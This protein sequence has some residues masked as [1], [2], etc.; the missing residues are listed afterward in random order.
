MP[1]R[2]ALRP[3]QKMATFDLTILNDTVPI[4]AAQIEALLDCIYMEEGR[5]AERCDFGCGR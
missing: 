3:V 5:I 2:I 4:E 1:P